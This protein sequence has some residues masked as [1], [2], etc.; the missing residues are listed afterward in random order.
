MMSQ[1]QLDDEQ[2]GST[3]G[4]ALP[5]TSQLR[6]KRAVEPGL[7]PGQKREISGLHQSSNVTYT[8]YLKYNKL[9]YL[10]LCEDYTCSCGSHV[11]GHFM[12]HFGGGLVVGDSL[13]RWRRKLLIHF[14][15]WAMLPVS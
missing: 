14:F 7:A 4:P 5:S 3:R 12:S 11:T 8:K 6:E 13:F 9:A 2:Q 10:S 15:I 1:I